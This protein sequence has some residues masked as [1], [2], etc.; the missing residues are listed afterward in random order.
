[1]SESPFPKIALAG[2]GSVATHLGLA[3]KHAGFNIECVLNRSTER[4]LILAE[5]LDARFVTSFKALDNPDLL[6]VA[7]SDDA[8]P[9]LAI[10]LSGCSFPVVHTSGTVSKDVLSVVGPDYGVFYPLQTFSTGRNVD[11]SKVPICI[12]SSN[13]VFTMR[14]DSFAHSLSESVYQIAD[15][16]RKVLH[17]AGVFACNFSNYLYTVAAGILKNNDIPFDLLLPLIQETAIKIQTTEPMDAQTGPAKRG[18]ISTIQQH[19]LM[20]EN[21]PELLNLYK[22]LTDNIMNTYSHHFSTSHFLSKDDKQ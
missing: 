7:V 14:L 13:P 15:Q 8:I 3:L 19:L 21:E 11:F 16:Q 2:A 22:L 5:K 10:Q 18:D 6:I 9:A 12:D 4:G 17:L 20:L 1:M